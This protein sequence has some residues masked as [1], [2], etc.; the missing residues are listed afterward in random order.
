MAIP[1]QLTRRV[2]L[3]QFIQLI[4]HPLHGQITQLQ[5]IILFM[6]S[7]PTRS[8]PPTANV[9]MV[10]WEEDFFDIF[11]FGI[12]VFLV[13]YK[14][15]RLELA[16]SLVNGYRVTYMV[17]SSKHAGEVF[18]RLERGIKVPY[19]VDGVE[20]AEEMYFGTCAAKMLFEVL[21]VVLGFLCTF[22]PFAGLV[23]LICSVCKRNEL[24]VTLGKDPNR[25]NHASEKTGRE[26]SSGEAEHED[27]VS[28][29]E[30]SHDEAV[31]GND[32]LV[33]G[34]AYTLIYSSGQ[35]SLELAPDARIDRLIDICGVG[36]N[37]GC[38]R[39][40]SVYTNILCRRGD[41]SRW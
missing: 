34:G 19:R 1:N 13:L 18:L 41:D 37:T 33:E 39:R 2:F 22:E 3:P 4:D 21:H 15:R 26:G 27:F 17:R 25:C 12:G 32:M 8:K 23:L 20:Q 31:A 30:V 36:S 9:P 40:M 11:V 14:Q 10:P 6:C 29:V 35:P 5:R 7:L 28:G 24:F 38:R 16:A